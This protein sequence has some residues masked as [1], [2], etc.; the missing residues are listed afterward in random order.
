MLSDQCWTLVVHVFANLG[1]SDVV[2]MGCFQYT[3]GNIGKPA[4]KADLSN[5]EMF[6]SN[7]GLSLNFLTLERLILTLENN[8]I[9]HPWK[10]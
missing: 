7:I 1:N 4:S 9:Y 2:N 10:Y 5:S 3:F 6:F 8:F